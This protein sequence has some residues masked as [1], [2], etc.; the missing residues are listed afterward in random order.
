VRFGATKRNCIG[1]FMFRG[2]H[3]VC[4]VKALPDKNK[5]KEAAKW[6]VDQKQEDP[7]KD[8]QALLISALAQFV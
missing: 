7:S 4:L 8:A 6:I 2:K 5:A 1:S 3:N